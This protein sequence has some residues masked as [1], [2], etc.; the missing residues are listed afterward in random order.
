MGVNRRYDHFVGA[1]FACT[2]VSDSK[3]GLASIPPFHFVFYPN[4]GSDFA[5]E[6]LTSS[7]L[8]V[9][10]DPTINQGDN[11]QISHN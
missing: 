10:D 7:R 3:S 1:C 11:V 6:G 5:R 4:Y 9:F 8:M 2:D